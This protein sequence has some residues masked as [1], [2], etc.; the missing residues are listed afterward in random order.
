MF[1]NFIWNGKTDKVK[2]NIMMQN[3]ESGGLKMIEY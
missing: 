1:F 3:Y 2:R